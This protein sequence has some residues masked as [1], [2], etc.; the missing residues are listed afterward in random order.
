MESVPASLVKIYALHLS[1]S[2]LLNFDKLNCLQTLDTLH[3]SVLALWILPL[4]ESVKNSAMVLVK[5]RL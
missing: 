1:F 4:S 2:F 5:T 3:H